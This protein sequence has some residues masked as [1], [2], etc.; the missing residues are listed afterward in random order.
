M[1]IVLIHNDGTGTNEVG[2]YT[3]EVRVNH[4]VL[5]RGEIHDF[6]RSQ[7][8]RSLYRESCERGM[9]LELTTEEAMALRKLLGS[10]SRMTL[11]KQ[12]LNTKEAE[13]VQSL[14]PSLNESLPPSD[15]WKYQ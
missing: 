6:P 1:L 12:G 5:T 7:G 4:E 13:I 14:Y 2:N 9:T 8:W 10:M 11:E 3:Y 15:D